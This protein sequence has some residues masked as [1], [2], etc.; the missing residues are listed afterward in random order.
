MQPRVFIG[1][2]AEQIQL[3]KRIEDKLSAHFDCVPWTNGSVFRI[4]KS[5]LESLL[6]QTRLSDFAILVATKDDVTKDVQQK[7]KKKTTLRDNVLFEFGLFLGATGIDKAFLIAEKGVDL[8]SDINGITVLDFVEDA[9]AHN[10]LDKICDKVIEEISLISGTSELGLLPSTALAVGYYLSFVKRA[11]ERLAKK[12]RLFSNGKEISVKSFKL[13]IVIPE[14]ID[15]NGV[16]D[17]LDRYNMT[18][19]L[20]EAQTTNDPGN[21]GRGYPFHFKI[22]PPEQDA[23]GEID[24]HMFDVPTTINTLVESIKLYHPKTRVGDDS[25]RAFLEKRELENFATVLRHYIKKSAWTKDVVVVI[26]GAKL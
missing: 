23:D 1:S 17:F 15:E 25:D 22:D 11:C 14:E 24:V 8:P 13:H 18:N 7:R 26:E 3:I 9:N 6:R 10:S 20:Q 19:G 4:N 16:D 2:S 12:K 5:A 21:Q